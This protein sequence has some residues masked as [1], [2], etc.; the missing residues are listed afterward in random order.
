M[1]KFQKT[2]ELDSNKGPWVTEADV[3]PG[4]SRRGRAE[5]LDFPGL[6]RRGA[7]AFFGPCC[8]LSWKSGRRIFGSGF[9]G[10][11]FSNGS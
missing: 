4:L 8:E 10:V 11:G 6:V 2:P 1:L 3:S 9:G 7:A 5:E